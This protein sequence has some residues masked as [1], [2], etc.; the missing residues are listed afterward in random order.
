MESAVGEICI[1]YPYK[2]TTESEVLIPKLPAPVL[3]Q[4]LGD[5]EEKVE[6][7]EGILDLGIEGFW[8]DI[9]EDVGFL[10]GRRLKL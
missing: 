10:D 4:M 7:S 8:V 6:I 9:L 2:T 5:D 1:W 3:L